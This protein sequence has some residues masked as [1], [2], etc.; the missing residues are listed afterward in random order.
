MDDI[1]FD[2]NRSP[3]LPVSH[4]SPILN[5][6]GEIGVYC[7]EA[8]PIRGRRGHGDRK[9]R[10]MFFLHQCVIAVEHLTEVQHCRVDSIEYAGVFYGR[11]TW[12]ART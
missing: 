2:P 12:M 5:G 10:A 4:M 9:Q 3:A 7:L 8:V 11:H 1:A 6:S